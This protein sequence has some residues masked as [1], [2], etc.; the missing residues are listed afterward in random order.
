M[1][2][3]WNYAIISIPHIVHY[4]NV[5]VYPLYYAMKKLRIRLLIPNAS[6]YY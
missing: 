6:I 2:W 4:E 5:Y 3:L 1:F